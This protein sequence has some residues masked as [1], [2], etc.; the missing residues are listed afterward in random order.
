MSQSG[1]QVGDARPSR[2]QAVR[3]VAALACVPFNMALMNSTFFPQFGDIFTY[4]RDLGVLTAAAMC[5]A[6]AAVS[7]RR[8]MWLRH[9]H[10]TLLAL[11]LWVAGLATSFW[12]ISQ[13]ATLPLV[14][15]VM[16]AQAGEAWLELT[17][18]LAC[19][20][21]FEQDDMVL[22]TA[23][24]TGAGIL[25]GSA[26]SLLPL[27]ASLGLYLVSIPAGVLLVWDVSRRSVGRIA[28]TPAGGDL[29][30]TWPSSFL[31]PLNRFYLCIFGFAVATGYALRFGALE[32]RADTSP[33]A[34]LA[35]AAAV[36]YCRLSKREER[37]DALLDFALLFTV[38]GFLLVPICELGLAAKA[39]LSVGDAF[40]Q[41]VSYLALF[42]LA[43]RNSTAGLTVVA[44][45]LF[46]TSLG[47][48][49]GANIGALA[50]TGVDPD[51]A[52]LA[53]SLVAFALLAFAL[54]GLR[55]FSFDATI[56]GVQPVVDLA[57]T[58]AESVRDIDAAC[59]RIARS[60]GLTARETD[61]LRLLARG[62]NNSHI[63]DEL[64]LARNTVKSHIKHV[65]TKLDVHSQQELIDLVDRQG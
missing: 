58:P 51:A 7:N 62:R 40:F 53:S 45:G 39:S 64:T 9:R 24:G 12:G 14:A 43:Q 10:H 11:A 25:L 27:W 16:V 42:S 35:L 36:P 47:T 8:P 3:A 5:L 19:S 46:W 44:W 31:S 33:F 30:L 61:V 15:G 28:A 54:F 22:K 59:E 55:G 34:I 21:A 63:Q 32:G 13:A 20:E 4:G 49:L 6:I 60:C 37:F 23:A 26:A 52:Y 50:W 2:G 65:Y 29:A 1:T 41:L 57:P 17:I 56:R 48:T 38:G 18:L